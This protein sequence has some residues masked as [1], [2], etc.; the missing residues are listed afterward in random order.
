MRF[1]RAEPR[2]LRDLA[3]TAF[4]HLSG[5]DPSQIVAQYD[6]W[7]AALTGLEPGDVIIQHVTLSV[8]PEVPAGRYFL[9][10]GLYSPQTGQRLPVRGDATDFVT[11]GEVEIV[12]P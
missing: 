4:V 2:S 8:P 12:A 3:P 10:A 6:G 9:R 1:P 7:D 5:E 11:L